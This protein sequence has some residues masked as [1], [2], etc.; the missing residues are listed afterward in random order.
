[1]S[2]KITFFNASEVEKCAD[3]VCTFL[4]TPGAVVLVPT[5]TVYGLIANFGDEIAIEKIYHLKRRPHNKKLGCFVR[6]WRSLSKYGVVLTGLPEQLA[7]K[8]TPGAITIIAPC[9]NG[10][11]L[12]FRVPDHPLLQSILK[13]LDRPLIQTSANASGF[14]DAP[15]CAEALKQLD[16]EVDCAIDGGAV[17]DN[18]CGSTVVDATGTEIRI[19]R[20]G[21]VDLN[22]LC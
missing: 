1:M 13:K 2:S 9:E 10:D 17:A 8:Y 22:K 11:T 12:G 14:P 21:A 7:E 18:A 19:L 20:Q 16:G 6:D 15:S 3:K 5:E 4:S